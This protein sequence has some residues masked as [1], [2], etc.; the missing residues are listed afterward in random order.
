VHAFTRLRPA[1]ALSL[2][3]SVLT[4]APR[5]GASPVDAPFERCNAREYE[6]LDQLIRWLAV[7][8]PRQAGSIGRWDSFRPPQTFFG[9]YPAHARLEVA[10]FTTRRPAPGDGLD[11]YF[12]DE[13]RDALSRRGPSAFFEGLAVPSPLELHR[14]DTATLRP[15]RQ[16]EVSVR[17]RTAGCFTVLLLH[18]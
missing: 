13:G 17:V 1:L 11:G 15:P 16:G 3:L 5:G 12:G 4:G 2:A 9:R 6:R 14:L 8:H 10:V 7:A 18:P